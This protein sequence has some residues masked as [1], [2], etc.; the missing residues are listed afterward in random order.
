MIDIE[1]EVFNEAY[2]AITQVFPTMYVV[3]EIVLNPPTL[4][5]VCIEEISNSV[6]QQTIDSGSNENWVNLDYEARVYVNNTSLKK[7]NAR[8]I[9]TTVDEYFLAKGFIRTNSSFI[10]FDDGTKYEMIC[11]YSC[12]ANNDYIARR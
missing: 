1:P 5:C 9:M 2:E 8:D 10:G 3:N 6:N 12:T 11:R 4:P 7:K